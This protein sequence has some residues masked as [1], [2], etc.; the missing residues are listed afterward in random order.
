MLYTTDTAGWAETYETLKERVWSGFED[1]AHQCEKKGGKCFS[2][3]SWF[4]DCFSCLT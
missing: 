4:D 2:R 3:I 1:I